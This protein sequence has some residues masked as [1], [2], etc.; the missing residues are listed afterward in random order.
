MKAIGARDEDIIELNSDYEPIDH[1]NLSKLFID[2]RISSRANFRKGHKT[3][4]FVYYVGH[5]VEIKNSLHAVMDAD[6]LTPESQMF[7]PIEKQLKALCEVQESYVISVF[8]SSR[9]MTRNQGIKSDDDREIS[10]IP[11]NFIMTKSCEVNSRIDTRPSIALDYFRQLVSMIDPMDGSI[12]LP[13]PFFSDWI[14]GSNGETVAMIQDKLVLFT[15]RHKQHA[16]YR[17]V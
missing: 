12:M 10:G 1:D 16:Q 4:I 11:R 15:E 13:Q 5:G 14:P 8:D 17:P 7:Y 3:L 2:L 6:D 9:V